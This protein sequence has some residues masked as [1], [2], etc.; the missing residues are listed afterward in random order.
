MTKQENDNLTETTRQAEKHSMP[1][2]PT[3]VFAWLPS[4]NKH[5][6]LQDPD[7]D[8]CKRSGPASSKPNPEPSPNRISPA[9]PR[10]MNHHWKPET[11]AS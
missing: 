11:N 4:K 10:L 3:S 8:R 6:T 1:S 9:E 2:S 7:S 5:N